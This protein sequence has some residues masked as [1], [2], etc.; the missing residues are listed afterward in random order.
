MHDR[1]AEACIQSHLAGVRL[2]GGDANLAAGVDVHTAVREP[3]NGATHRVGDAHAKRPARLD[4]LQRLCHSTL[5]CP[6]EGT[7]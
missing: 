5:T 1:T 6:T 7:S 2:C 4:V 3:R